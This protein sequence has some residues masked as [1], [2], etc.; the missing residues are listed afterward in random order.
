MAAGNRARPVEILLVEDNLA[1][2]RLT[3]EAMKE[4]RMTNALHV[5]RSGPEAQ[6]F[7]RRRGDFSG[8]PRPDLI[9]L[10][11]NLPGMDGHELLADIKADE[12]LR[13]IPVVVLTSS[14]ADDDIVE[15]Y[16]LHANCFISKPVTMTGFVDVV[17]SVDGFWFSIVKLPPE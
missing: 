12:K 2:I 7:L 8:A 3:Q 11:L 6:Q 10:D 1:D 14:S 15:S 16:N 5:V 17:H 13:R 4:S 9:L